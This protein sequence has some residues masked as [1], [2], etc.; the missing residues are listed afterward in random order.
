MRAPIIKTSRTSKDNTMHLH[1]S[2]SLAKSEA[3]K[4]KRALSV[5]GIKTSLHDSQTLIAKSFGYASWNAFY[6]TWSEA[7]IPDIPIETVNHETVLHDPKRHYWETLPLELRTKEALCRGAELISAVADYAPTLS[8]AVII[9]I[10]NSVLETAFGID[11]YYQ[12][13]DKEGVADWSLMTRRRLND[14][15]GVLGSQDEYNDA[16]MRWAL[17]EIA[18]HGG[19][20][21]CTTSRFDDYLALLRKRKDPHRP[22]YVLDFTHTP[23]LFEDK[24]TPSLIDVPEKRQWTTD[25]MLS[26]WTRPFYD[27]AITSDYDATEGALWNSRASALLDIAIDTLKVLDEPA[28]P[29]SLH[30][31][32][33]FSRA[34]ENGQDGRLTYELRARWTQAL[35]SVNYHYGTLATSSTE[36]QW[37]H[38]VKVLSSTIKEF[39]RTQKLNAS[40][41]EPLQPQ[42]LSTERPILVMVTES[43][44]PEYNWLLARHMR[45]IMALCDQ[46]KIQAPHLIASEQYAIDWLTLADNAQHRKW[47]VGRFA[48]IPDANNSL[49]GVA[50]TPLLT[51]GGL[52]LQAP[53][54]NTIPAITNASGDW[55][56]RSRQQVLL[57]GI[58]VASEE[59]VWPTC[60]SIPMMS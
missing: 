46:G 19:F 42:T 59:M 21:T 25:D 14:G 27:P 58:N 53:K 37:E 50:I 4:L 13:V 20:L 26:P 56:I 5:C 34:I 32:L 52:L 54:H 1:R 10:T 7:V 9:G 35:N 3:K 8:E 24:A 47:H 39:S 44:A 48:H 28:T 45:A 40:R 55:V 17:P 6:V 33:T 30:E 51:H 15:V 36:Q 16:L 2:L 43:A 38:V 22:L 41:S 60:H 49:A 31:Q 23:S 12:Y 18:A 29:D 57:Q 11:R